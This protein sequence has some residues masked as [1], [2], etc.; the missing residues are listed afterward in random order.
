[1]EII[2]AP[3]NAAGVLAKPGDC[4]VILAPA[5]GS[6]QV[7]VSTKASDGDLDASVRMEPLA[8]AEPDRSAAAAISPPALRRPVDPAPSVARRTGDI[9]SVYAGFAMTAHVARRGDLLVQSGEWAGGPSAPAPIEGLQIN[10]SPP[11]GVALE[12]QVLVVGAEGRWS[13]WVFAGEFAGSRGRRLPLAGIRLRLGGDRADG[14]ALRG[15]ALFLGSAVVSDTGRELEFLS[16]SGADPLVGL[17]LELLETN[18]DTHQE[19]PAKISGSAKGG[20]GEAQRGGRVRVFRSGRTSRAGM[21]TSS[22][23]LGERILN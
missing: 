4:V 22:D 3:G 8:A 11:A 14:Y 6:L 16:R 9:Q 15:E 20:I 12:S 17:R 7:T 19:Q 1:V 13:T 18:N 10:W 21:S 5:S 23:E 2:S